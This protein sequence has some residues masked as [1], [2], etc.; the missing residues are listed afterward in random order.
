MAAPVHLNRALVLEVPERAP[1][2][3][4]GHVVTWQPR[5]TLWAELR[6]R[7]GREAAEGAAHLARASYRIT[8]RAA[9][10]G[11]PSRPEAGQRF[12]MGARLFAILAVLEA[13]QDG[14]LLTYFAEEEVA[15]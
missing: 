15:Q 13:G 1:D 14:R 3:A 8:L 4:G 12:R 5:G 6:A 9:P 7:T 11:S 10:P 2:G